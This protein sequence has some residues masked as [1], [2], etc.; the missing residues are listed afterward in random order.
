MAERTNADHGLVDAW[1]ADLGGPRTAALLD[2]LDKA[3]A[4][5]TLVEP[6]AALPEY[7]GRARGEP[8]RGG[9]PAGPR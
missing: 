8:D 6:I 3:V 2:R 7:R 5:G 1:T 9:R 4:W